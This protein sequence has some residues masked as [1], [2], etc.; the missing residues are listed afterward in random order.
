M[1]FSFFGVESSIDMD[2]FGLQV[3]GAF[4]RS[5]LDKRSLLPGVLKNQCV[6]AFLS[7]LIMHK[8]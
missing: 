8:L 1:T 6:T 3:T 2:I 5:S 7:D 4:C